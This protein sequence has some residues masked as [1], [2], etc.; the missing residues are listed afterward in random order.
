V[1]GALFVADENVV[2]VAVLEC[3]VGGEDGSAG[4]A[5]D[6][7]DVFAL[8]AFPQDLCSGLGHQ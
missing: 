1:G 5:E 8:E 2:N 7:G 6:G 3:V 4:I